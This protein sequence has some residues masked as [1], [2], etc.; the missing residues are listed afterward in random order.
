MLGYN[1]LKG[2]TTRK[3]Y[4]LLPDLRRGFSLAALLLPKIVAFSG[5]NLVLI[6][7]SGQKPL[8]LFIKIKQFK[9]PAKNLLALLFIRLFSSVIVKRYLIRK[10]SPTTASSD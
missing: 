3:T 7:T 9:I 2:E 10:T 5:R 1:A 8:K 6:Y 4:T